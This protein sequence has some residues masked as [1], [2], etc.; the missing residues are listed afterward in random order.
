MFIPLPGS[1][2]YN[3]LSSE[4]KIDREEDLK[5][6]HFTLCRK[7]FC[8]VSPERLRRKYEEINN[9]FSNA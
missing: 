6:L 7:S 4:G 9:Y 1:E 5:D 8:E 3:Q 2:L